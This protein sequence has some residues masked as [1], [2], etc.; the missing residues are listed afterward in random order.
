MTEQPYAEYSHDL[1]DAL[2]FR[3]VPAEAATQIVR[4]VE[5]HTA[6]SGEDPVAAFGQPGDYADNF[7]PRSRLVRFWALVISSVVLA[8]GGA[9]VL[10]SGVFG[11]LSP[12]STL[13]GL[14]PWVRVI[15]GAAGIAAFVVLV[16][17]AGA[18]SKRSASSWR[19]EAG[20]D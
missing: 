6:E 16:L 8:G 12:S 17:M 1:R 15:L 5:S 10:I 19:A 4:E 2:E 7:A 3:G 13:W 20:R 9:Y 18:R 14:P 11:L